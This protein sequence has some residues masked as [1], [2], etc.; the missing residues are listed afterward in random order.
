MLD[1][2]ELRLNVDN[3]EEAVFVWILV[4][5]QRT[6]EKE[7]AAQYLT[8][9]QLSNWCLHCMTGKA[10]ALDSLRSETEQG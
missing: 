5:L 9:L 4:D 3:G 2:D 7:V 8:H 1:E 6:S 10:T